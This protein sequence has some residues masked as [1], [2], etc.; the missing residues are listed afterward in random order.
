MK[1]SARRECT[2][3]KLNRI[4][5]KLGN[6]RQN[7]VEQTS[8]SMVRDYDLIALEKLATANMVRKVAPKPD[9]ENPGTFLPNG[10]AAKS[11]LNRAIHASCW[12]ML[13]A[14]LKDKS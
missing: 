14:R 8:T 9:P 13:A 4:R 1:G 11:G 12:G 2:K 3:R 5:D 10:A 7:W 6:R